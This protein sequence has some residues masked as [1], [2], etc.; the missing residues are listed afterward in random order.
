F[1]QRV[2]S[3]QSGNTTDIS[4]NENFGKPISIRRNSEKI[5]YEYYGD[6]QVKIKAS[7]TVRQAFEY[8]PQNKKVSQVT[9]TFFNEKGAKVSTKKS[10][11]KYDAKGNLTYAQ[12]SDGQKI[13]MTYDNKGRI[14]TITDQAKKVVKIEYEDRYGKPALVTRPGLGTIRVS[15]KT[16]GD[17]NKVE[18]K[19]GP[20]VAM[21]VASTF[22]NLLD[23]V[24]PATSEIF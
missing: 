15:Y 24:A 5:S 17:I 2:L 3:T 7:P 20:S 4:Y 8:D 1:L 14:A 13:N 16:N 22:N 9:S 6:G 21:Q 12:N 19:E 23:V 10:D 18:S 11:F